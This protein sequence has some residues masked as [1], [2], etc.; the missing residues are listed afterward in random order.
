[1]T[2]ELDDFTEDQLIL[3]IERFSESIK[4]AGELLKMFIRYSRAGGRDAATFT[5]ILDRMAREATKLALFSRTPLDPDVHNRALAA[6]STAAQ[7]APIEVSETR[8]QIHEQLAMSTLTLTW[9]SGWHHLITPDDWPDDLPRVVLE[10]VRSAP[11]INDYEG[12]DELNL[13]DLRAAGPRPPP[14]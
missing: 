12:V 4:E 5:L 6:V 8:G 7:R 9:M 3:M 14:D 10:A 11:S 2:D 1:M 13:D